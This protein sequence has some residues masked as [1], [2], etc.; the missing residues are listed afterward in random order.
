MEKN[1]IIPNTKII[2][3][4]ANSHQGEV[5]QAIKLAN[6]CIEAGADAVKFQVYSA[7]ELLHINHQRFQ[8]FKK[9]SFNFREWNT[10]FKKIKKKNAKIYCDVFGLQSFTIAQNKK[11]D[12]FKVHSSDL[13]NKNLLDN[14][15]KIKKKDIFLSTGG[16]TLREISYAVNILKKRKIIP[17]LMHGY[18]SY[19]TEIKDTNLNRINL[20]KSIF[21]ESCFYGLQD[22]I[23]GDDEMSKI[24][25][26]VS[27]S[28]NLDFIEKHVT[29]NRAKQGV[30]YF[31]SIEPQNLKK[32]INQVNQVKKCF[33]KNQLNFSKSE[34][35]YRN[36]VKKIWYLNK[37]FK[38]NEKISNKNLIMLR[39]SSSKIA[40]AFIEKFEKLNLNRSYKKNTSVSYSI[41]DKKKV[42]AIIVS[43]LKSQ[44]LPNKA[45][46]LINQE[47]LITHLIKRLKLAKN[48]DKIVLATTKNNEDLKICNEAKKNKINFFR[49]DE[50]NVLKRMHDAAKKFKFNI[51][52]RITGDDI[53]IDPIYLDKLIKYHI[54]SNLEY[55]NNKDLPGGTEVEIFSFD[56]LKFLLNTIIDVDNTEYLTFFI[57]E[58]IDQFITGS[59]DVSKKH[60]SNKSL[61]IDTY[62][63][64]MFVKKFL[65]D[66]KN[67]NLKYEYSLD[68]IMNFLNK[69]TR[70]K[71]KIKKTI[72][73][74][75][76]LNWEKLLN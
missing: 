58:H 43:R 36:Q 27:L 64:Y 23:A 56:I 53:L 65:K 73:V 41:T 62:E 8:H 57:Q 21:K 60:K 46:K 42:G 1:L 5:D 16:S 6:K 11:V 17:I 59:L 33:G 71:R 76:E 2:A 44:R 34:K 55:S 40:P 68:H 22:H 4:V 32:L 45:L 30:D 12:G 3:E 39:P 13:I 51:V 7:E 49:G 24:I 25:P 26:L 63:D 67:K 48:I 37:D 70:K 61:T 31:S 47:P 75:T 15:S 28:L 52:I 29:L 18:Q 66:M 35:N 38:K 72:K 9:Q 74:N 10:I 54:E 20:L 19:P 14:L 69:N 50:K